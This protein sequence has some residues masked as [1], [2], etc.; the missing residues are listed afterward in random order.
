MVVAR[1]VATSNV[2]YDAVVIYLL[3]G[4][5]WSDVYAVLEHLP[6][7]SFNLAGASAIEVP[8]FTY[9]S[10]VTLTTLGY[11]D[12]TP[13]TD[14]ARSLAILEAVIGQLYMTVLVA[15]LVGLLI[16]HSSRK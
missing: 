6:P 14:Q 9:Y 11:G 3:I 2:V 5:T 13:L 15:R 4:I 12:V 10:F 1:L 8:A 16:S 7:G